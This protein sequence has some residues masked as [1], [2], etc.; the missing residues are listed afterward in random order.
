[1]SI[2]E[3]SNR[4]YLFWMVVF[5]DYT[6]KVLKKLRVSQEADPEQKKRGN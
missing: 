2:L 4:P 3:E 6:K 5:G 1:M